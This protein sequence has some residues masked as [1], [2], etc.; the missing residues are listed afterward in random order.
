MDWWAEF[1]D[2]G[3]QG[4]WFL[5]ETLATCAS[6]AGYLEIDAAQRALAAAAVLAV[7]SSAGKPNLI[8]LPDALELDGEVIDDDLRRLALQALDR[9]DSPDSELMAVWD[10]D[11]VYVAVVNQIRSLV[12]S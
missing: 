2:S 3:P 5:R 10:G 1:Q 7:S 6:S 4:W 8:S 12:A 9:I 11:E